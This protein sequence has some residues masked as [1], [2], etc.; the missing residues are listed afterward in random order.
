MLNHYF[1]FILPHLF[2]G[3]TDFN[4]HVEFTTIT[5]TRVDNENGTCQEK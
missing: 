1:F 4:G 2:N 3:L 5:T